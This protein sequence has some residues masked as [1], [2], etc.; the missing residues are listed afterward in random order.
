MDATPELFPPSETASLWLVGCE[1]PDLPSAVSFVCL[2]VEVWQ[3]TVL[4]PEVDELRVKSPVDDLLLV[5]VIAAG[6]NPH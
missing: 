3:Q 2:F 5:K 6:V 1:M 4:P